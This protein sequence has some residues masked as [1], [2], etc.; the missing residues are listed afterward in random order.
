M[1]DILSVIYTTDNGFHMGQHRQIG[2][3]GLPYLE[4]TNIPMTIKGPGVPH[5]ITTKT[6]SS[7]TDMAP[8]FLEI[9][10]LKKGDKGYP[11]FFDGRSLV[12]EWKNPENSRSAEKEILNVEFWG[13]ISNAGVPDFELRSSIYAY[14]TVRIMSETSSWL[15][16]K[17]CSGND[18]ELYDT[19]VS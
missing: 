5:G 7:H 15:F 4:D 16:S 1:T 12:E 2:G 11:V 8:T 9:A 6:P 19:T 13:T 10:G 14:K 18:T 3:K 17:W